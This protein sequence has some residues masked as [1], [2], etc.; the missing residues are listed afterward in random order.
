MIVLLQLVV[1]RRIEGRRRTRVLGVM[2]LVWAASWLL[3]GSSG[4]VPGTLG[5]SLL[6]A[7]G[8][9]VFALGETLLQPTVPVLVNA[10][11][12]DHLRGRYNAV[13]GA[14]FSTAAIIAPPVAGVLI[15]HG[16]GGVQIALLVGG[17]LACGVLAVGRLE[18]DLPPEANGVVAPVAGADVSER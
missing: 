6:V 12:P 8:M 13:S 10:L 18:R 14:A 17:C 11:A 15:G 5:A 3:L 16:L 1:L 4:L 7:G 2:S 9:M